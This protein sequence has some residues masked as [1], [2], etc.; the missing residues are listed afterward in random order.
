MDDTA[1]R[2]KHDERILKAFACLR[3]E[4]L[5]PHSKPSASSAALVSS[6]S[7]ISEIFGDMGLRQTSIEP[8][9]VLQASKNAEN[10]KVKKPRK[11]TDMLFIHSIYVN[12][13]T[14]GKIF[15]T[16]DDLR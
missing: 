13:A 4:I 11:M 3:F 8:E 1:C 5:V 9:L 2:G 10:K 14:F 16:R 12:L 15:G 6:S 7:C